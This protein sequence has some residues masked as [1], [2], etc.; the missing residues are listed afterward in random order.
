MNKEARY[1]RQLRL[2]ADDGQKILETSHIC[3][4]GSTA[5]ITETLKNLVLPGVGTVAIV[6]DRYRTDEDI[7]NKFFVARSDFGKKACSVIS[8]LLGELNSS[9]KVEGLDIDPWSF[10]N[11]PDLFNRFS[12]VLTSSYKRISELSAILY[13]R[14]IPLVHVSSKGFFGSLR[15]S[16][17]HH[18][19]MFILDSL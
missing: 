18:I 10:L 6:D 11:S 19:G 5:C 12:L 2:W 7:E 4:L 16:V 8:N 1:D 14:N 15:L 17:P 3:A 9:V 13:S